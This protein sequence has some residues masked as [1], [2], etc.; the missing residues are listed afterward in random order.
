MSDDEVTQRLAGIPLFSGLKPKHLNLIAQQS[1]IVEFGPGSE[2][3]K[4]G[5]SGVGLHVIAEGEVSVSVGGEA[6]RQMGPGSFF[7]EIALLDGGP[8]SATV[9]AADEVVT[10]AIPFWNFKNL[11]NEY[12]EIAVVMLE[13][14]ARRL[15][16]KSEPEEL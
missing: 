14:T 2:I 1:K 10:V 11:L 5:E 4:E 15:R 8:R 7:G 16:G 9:V 12:P 13:E 3:C 6:V